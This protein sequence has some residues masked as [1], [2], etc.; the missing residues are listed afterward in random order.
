MKKIFFGS[1]LLGALLTACSNDDD[2]NA[3]IANPQASDPT[4]T[5]SFGNGKVTEVGVINLAEI[6]EETVKVADIVTPTMT[7]ETAKLDSMCI[8]ILELEEDHIT[9]ISTDGT[10]SK[11]Y[12]ASKLQLLYGMRPLEREITAVLSAFLSDGNQAFLINSDAFSIKAV[13]ASPDIEAAYYFTGTLNGWDNTNTDYKL[14]NDGSDPYENPVYTCRI[15]APEDGSDVMFKMTPESGLGGDWSGCL[16]G[17]TTDGTFDYNNTGGDLVIP[18]VEGAVFYDLTFN[19]LDLTWSFTPLFINIEPAY[20]FTGTLN[21]W[22]NNDT[23]YKLTN[24]GGDPYENPTFTCRIPAPEDGSDVMFKMT[25]ESGLGGDWSGC[26]AG[27]GSDGTF[28]YNNGGGDLFI[29]AVEGAKFYDLTF[30]M[31]ELTW[32]YSAVTFDPYVYFIGATDGW[33]A[34]D[35]KLAATEDG[36][37]SGY[38]YVADPNGWGLE[39]KF[40]L[41]PGN[42]DKQLNSQNL[43]EISGDFEKGDDNIKASAGEGVYYVNLDLNTNVLNATKITNMNLVGDFNSWSPNDDAQQMTW[44]AENYCYVIT[45]AGVNANGWKFTANNAWDINLGANDTVEPSSV[46]DDLVGFGKN[47]NAVG[48]TIKLYPTRKTSDKIYCTVE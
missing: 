37:Y 24:N 16:S 5:H 22:N 35:Q 3:G 14:T 45:G 43:A 17:S 47:L 32:S 33:A 48:T 29:Q 44:D 27:G 18:A 23:S 40:Q 9:R 25:P 26:L 1:L 8:S 34:S 19:M 39:F 10:I 7:S 30:N 31:M 6:T 4:V 21:G 41:E 20:Y 2:Y 42:W 38:L 13:P 12:L 15:P 46:I 28:V 36:V 11:D